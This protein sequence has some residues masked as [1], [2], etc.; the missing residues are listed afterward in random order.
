MGLYVSP[1]PEAGD[2]TKIKE[3]IVAADLPFEQA[4]QNPAETSIA[5]A[6]KRSQVRDVVGTAEGDRD[7]V[8]NFPS[9]LRQA[10]AIIRE[11]DYS[12]EMV[13]PPYSW[14]PF[15][16]NLA[17]KPNRDLS[18]LWKSQGTEQ[19]SPQSHFRIPPKKLRRIHTVVL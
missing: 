1:I 13:V 10:V 9:V 15:G 2:P 14:I 3:M 5:S 16:Y 19:V 8:V 11:A 12:S 7:N 18:M 6:M 4:A 17:F